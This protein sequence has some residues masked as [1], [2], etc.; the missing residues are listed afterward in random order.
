ML[1]IRSNSSKTWYRLMCVWT[2]T[3]MGKTVLV[4]SP[5]K[6]S[7][8]RFRSLLRK[9]LNRDQMKL[10]TFKWTGMDVGIAGRKSFAILDD[11]PKEKQDG[12]QVQ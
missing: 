8:N 6:E 2:W 11:L 12:R 9:R 4:M 3:A 1:E 7:S 5:D 10:V